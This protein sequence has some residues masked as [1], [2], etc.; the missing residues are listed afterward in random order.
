MGV[1]PLPLFVWGATDAIASG[2]APEAGGFAPIEAAAVSAL[3]T[4]VTGLAVGMVAP[5]LLGES[6]RRIRDAPV[7]S[8]GNGVM[9]LVLVLLV[10]FL[11]G[12]SIVLTPLM[13]VLGPLFG[14]LMLVAGTVGAMGFVGRFVDGYGPRLG[15]AAV[16]LGAAAA[17]PG[18]SIVAGIVFGAT[19]LGAMAAAR[20]E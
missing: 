5:R 17:I 9:V 19:G 15:G 11:V 4:L 2:P 1:L 20:F 12:A 16:V 10:L 3:L 7:G 8:F 14:V 6:I 13:L 18:P